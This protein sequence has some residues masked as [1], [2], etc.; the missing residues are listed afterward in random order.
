MTTRLIIA[1]HGNTFEKGQT[2]TRVGG[3][4]DLSLVETERGTNVGL[5]L[6]QEK[7][8]PAVVYAAPLKR[9]TQTA[10]LA[11]KALGIDL[12]VVAETSFTEIDYGPDENKTEDEVIARIGQEA[13]DAWNKDATVPNGWIVKPKEII[14]N[15]VDFGNDMM[16][17]YTDE[18]ILIVSSNGIIR[19][20]PYLTGDFDGFCAEHDIKVGTGCVCVFER[21]SGEDNWRCVVWNV[22]PK[23]V[24][25]GM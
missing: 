4:T 9:T 12:P 18:N 2:P 19:F 15:W 13:I 7:L 3:R 8:I 23:D 21:E 1:R 6:K 22:K 20:A 16:T 5:Y 25:A 24:L 14:Q 17:K 10:E 11:V